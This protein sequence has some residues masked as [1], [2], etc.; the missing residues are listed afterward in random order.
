MCTR[1]PRSRL[2]AG[3][4][5]AGA[6]FAL[7]PSASADETLLLQEPAVSKSHVVFVYA[8]DLWVVGR[9]GGEA[10]RLTSHAGGESTPRISPD[11]RTVAF[12]GSY[13]G[14]TD[15]YVI[16]IEGG[17]PKRLTWH[18]GRDQVRDWH[19]DGKRVLFASARGSRAPT[20]RL[21]LASVDGG[22]PAAL[23]IPR[24]A[25]A[26]YK[27]DTSRLAYTPYRDAFRTWKR[28]RGGLLTEIWL[29]DPETFQ[30][31]VVPHVHANDTF[32][33]W[34]G[35]D[36]YFASDRDDQMNLYRFTPGSAE[37]VQITHFTDFDVRNMS[38]GGG[39]V[40]YEQAGALHLY[41]PAKNQSRRLKIRVRADG[42]AARAEWKSV[43]GHVRNASIAPN[44]KRAVFEARGEIL[45]VPREHGDVRNLTNTPGVHERSPVWSPDGTQLAWFSDE[46]GEY[47]LMVG[48][49][50]GRGDVKAYDLGDGGFYSNP[51]YSPDGKHLL[52]VDKTNRIAYVTLETGAVTEVARIQ[53]SLGEVRP[54]AVWSPDSAWIAYELRN[55]RTMYDRIVL[56]EVASGT[57]TSI[58]DAFGN[59]GGPAFSRDGKHLFFA[60]SVDSGPN[61]F[62]LDMNASASRNP[63]VS[64]YVAVLRESA[65]NPMAARSDEA[66]SDE[67]EKKEDG[68][69]EE[70]AEEEGAEEEGAE[71]NEEDAGPSIDLPGIDQRILALPLPAGLYGSTACADDKLFFT[72]FDPAG[73]RRGGGTLKSFDFTSRKATTVSEG[74]AGFE[75]SDDGKSLL[76]A[77]GGGFSLS[78]LS[79]S[80]K[81]S[82]DINSAKVY[83]DPAQEWPQIVREAWR[84]ERDYF[85]DQNMHGVDWDAMWDRWQPFIAHARHRADL[86]IVLSELIGEL[87]CGHNYVGGGDMPSRPSG[88]SGGLLGADFDIE[89]GHFK[90]AR[91]YEGQ[92]WNPRLRSPLTEPGVDVNEGDFL[93]AVD[94]RPITADMNLFAAFENTSGRQLEISVSANADGSDARTSTVRPLGSDGQLRRLSWVEDNRR[95]VDAL[96]G[97]KLGYIYMPNT[98]GAGMASFD[99]DYYSQLDKQGM[100]ID[101]R[102]NGGGWVADYVI[103]VLNREALCYWT[104]REDWAA[105]SPFGSTSGPKV[106]ICNESSGSGGDWMPWAFQKTG[107]GPLVGRRTWGGLVGTSG[108]PPLMDGGSVTS[109]SFG[110]RATDGT[111]I[112]ENEGVT[113]DH[114]VTQ[115]PKDV[116]AGGDPQLEKAV[117]LAM[118]ALERNPPKALPGYTPPKER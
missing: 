4:I 28:Y 5:A 16:P 37:P 27:A 33:C 97:G 110:I 88:V 35:D 81:K 94:G 2:F 102:F 32:P 3:A 107:V 20:A 105:P 8:Q 115:W 87:C 54:G 1:I 98:A 91:I 72:Q 62:G 43:Q 41:D 76:L 73:S 55:D 113:P 23:P 71:E 19:P 103:N 40:V 12:T 53:G 83:S 30:V 11:G 100:I 57:S 116:I 67:S 104:N 14:N 75:I 59:A 9:G 50:L 95:R 78:G 82:L 101:E 64:L 38:S 36:V 51:D 22:M 93:I 10:R 106:M 46:S 13:D 31:E 108:Y 74:V 85:Y 18:A 47:Q 34:V 99:R 25:H 26:S 21:F 42:L 60:A 80:D 15:V 63:T 29:Y 61:L 90:V 24:V 69:K 48:D 56:Y 66:V 112:V 44:G 7:S 92:N 96:S 89:S 52:F 79:A 84:I 68:D 118:A 117:E 65:G 77:G 6:F 109:A 39:M 111:W 70:G 45:T 86:N 49:R 17:E 58:T 114:L